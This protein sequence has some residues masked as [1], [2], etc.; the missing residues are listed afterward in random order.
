M[1]YVYPLF[2]IKLTI[3]PP[4]PPSI[5]CSLATELQLIGLLG[6]QLWRVFSNF[7]VSQETFSKFGECFFCRFGC[8]GL[9]SGVVKDC[10]SRF[11]WYFLLDSPS[12]DRVMVAFSA[13]LSFTFCTN[14]RW[15]FRLSFSHIG[16]FSPPTLLIYPSLMH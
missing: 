16:S 2:C 5:L 14:S 11:R 1:G 3:C 8:G 7:S 6:G 12:V 13:K 15:I 9:S 10:A 4:L